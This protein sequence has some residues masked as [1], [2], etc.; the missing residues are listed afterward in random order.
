M[1]Y[2]GNRAFVRFDTLPSHLNRRSQRRY[3]LPKGISVY[4]YLHQLG[5]VQL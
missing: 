5:L 3:K 2:D 4:A 1:G